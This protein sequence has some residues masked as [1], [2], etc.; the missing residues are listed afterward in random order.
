MTDPHWTGNFEATGKVKDSTGEGVAGG[1]GGA[2][3]ILTVTNHVT[4]TLADEVVLVDYSAPIEELTL[5]LPLAA[6][7]LGKRYVIRIVKGTPA[8][9][10]P[11]LKTQ[12]ADVIIGEITIAIPEQNP[13][14]GTQLPLQDNAAQTIIS[15]GVNWVA[16]GVASVGSTSP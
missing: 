12:G 15:D 9:T 14:I 10:A 11:V 2:V 4:L 1:G 8:I 16:L 5:T 7:A 13:T 3:S 6:T